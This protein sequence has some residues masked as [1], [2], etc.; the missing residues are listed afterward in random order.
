MLE[1]HCGRNG[2]EAAHA[3]TSA[4]SL[5]VYLFDLLESEVLRDVV[6]EVEGQTLG[7]GQADE[8]LQV[9]VAVVVLIIRDKQ[10]TERKNNE[11]RW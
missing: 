1:L 2:C 7:V 9:D 10:R 8:L 5:F 6:G 11:S 4:V 3:R